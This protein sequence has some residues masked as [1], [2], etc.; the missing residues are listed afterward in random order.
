MFVSKC[1]PVGK[2]FFLSFLL[3][4]CCF[5]FSQTNSFAQL[6]PEAHEQ[7]DRNLLKQASPEDLQKYL[8]DKNQVKK[9]QGKIFTKDAWIN[10]EALIVNLKTAQ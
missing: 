7:I 3:L 8:K 5:F 2:Q 9:K 10:H 4:V 1:K 6:P